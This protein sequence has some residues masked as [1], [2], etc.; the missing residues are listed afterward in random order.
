MKKLILVLMIFVPEILSAANKEW[1]TG[2]I[3][4]NQNDTLKGYIAYRNSPDD[5]EKCLFKKDMQS[6]EFA[7][8]PNELISYRYNDGLYFQS[9]NVKTAHL[10]GK[11]FVE[12]LLEGII[13]L[14]CAQIDYSKEIDDQ[15]SFGPIV[16]AFL[17]EIP[18]DNSWVEII[19]P[20]D[21]YN[22]QLESKRNDQKLTSLF[23]NQIEKLK[24]DIPK[25]S[26]NRDKMVALFKK[27]H[28]LVCTDKACV[29]YKEADKKPSQFLTCYTSFGF[30]KRRTTD[31]L[32]PEQENFLCPMA[33]IGV[34]Y[35]R[36]LNKF[37]DRLRLNIALGLF[38]LNADKNSYYDKINY[39]PGYVFTDHEGNVTGPQTYHDIKYHYLFRSLGIYNQISIEGRL[40]ARKKI[41]P[42]L[43]IGLYQQ[44]YI[45]VK[46]RL[47]ISVQ[48]LGHNINPMEY[49]HYIV[50]IIA[51]AGISIN[52]EKY[53]IPIKINT[54]LPF[55]ESIDRPMELRTQFNLSVGYTFSIGKNKQ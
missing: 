51:S 25:S 5:Q 27:Y 37:T 32:D 48:E 42:L 38:Y 34:A 29:I 14:Y 53:Q 3:V 12:C 18:E 16:T 28:D 31:I 1:K 7:Y 19:C 23:I 33:H 4:T 47:D 39:N 52:K 44:V 8:T 50:G 6:S 13:N 11:Y 21:V 49:P 10:N 20:A 43:E 15:K 41:Q 35:N 24:N 55:T 17:V 46:N 45:P 26:Y 22:D 36:S 2:Y 40:M 30:Q 9:K 54:Y